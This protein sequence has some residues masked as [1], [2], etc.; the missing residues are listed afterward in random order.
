MY[1]SLHLEM[2]Y[3]LAP[4][5][6]EAARILWLELKY[7]KSEQALENLNKA[8]ERIREAILKALNDAMVM[9]VTMDNPFV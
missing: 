8:P 9:G 1:I 4:D 6:R 5:E 7:G 3:D 2:P